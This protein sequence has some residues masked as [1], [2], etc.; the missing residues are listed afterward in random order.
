M[1]K[2]NRRNKKLKKNVFWI[3]RFWVPV[4][5]LILVPLG[6]SYLVDRS[7]TAKEIV[8][9]INANYYTQA[10]YEF[11]PNHNFAVC[12]ILWALVFMGIF[13]FIR[14]MKKTEVFND[15]QSVYFKNCY[16]MLW[17]AANVLGYKKLQL[18][19]VSI[20]LQF[21]LVING[22]FSEFLT[23][24]STTQYE[25][26]DGDII[27]KKEAPKGNEDKVLNVLICDT[28]D[29]SFNQLAPNFKEYSVLKISSDKVGSGV[30]Y[31][32]PKLVKRVREEMFKAA[33]KYV[34]LNLFLTT[35][36]QNNLKIIGT[37][38]SALDRSGFEKIS[39]VQMDN[40]HIYKEPHIIFN[41]R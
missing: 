30:R 41:T 35:N 26:F 2:L 40:N 38:F 31:D 20:P 12:F 29:I 10:M 9:L 39:V 18:V 33:R 5:V 25:K 14:K 3:T 36:P 21:D 22:T 4:F 11:I 28:Y 6:I 1:N 13:T 34:E 32:N 19:G 7:L 27:V 15:N 16:W 37:S 17:V 24:S 23:E 8:K